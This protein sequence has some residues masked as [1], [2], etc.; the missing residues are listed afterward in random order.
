MLD[1][2]INTIISEYK[3]AKY[4]FANEFEYGNTVNT[5]Y[6]SFC[7]SKDGTVLVLPTI[8]DT[9]QNDYLNILADIDFGYLLNNVTKPIK[10]ELFDAL[11]KHCNINVNKLLLM[12]FDSIDTC[13]HKLKTLPSLG[14][15]CIPDWVIT[16]V[17]M[18]LIDL[19]NHSLVDMLS[20]TDDQV[21]KCMNNILNRA[22]ISKQSSIT[23]PV[24]TQ[25]SPRKHSSM[26]TVSSIPSELLLDGLSSEIIIGDD[27]T[28]DT[29]DVATGATDEYYSD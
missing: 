5:D 22:N 8:R 1:N 29:T 17:N 3:Q 15:P 20:I 24:F 23:I 6:Y 18:R 16:L 2:V 28:N 12:C 11:V 14:K 10:S 4:T 27:K 26:P 25:T 9:T 19:L 7:F 21:I 13:D